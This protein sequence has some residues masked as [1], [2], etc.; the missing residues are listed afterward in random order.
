MR[1]TATVSEPSA[2]SNQWSH[3]QS[4]PV[5]PYLPAFS[6]GANQQHFDTLMSETR[7]QNSEIRMHLCRLT[8]KID[9]ALQKVKFNVTKY[10]LLI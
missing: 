10:R 2:Y 3:Q 8:D 6:G 4:F 7:T 1:P 5:M 9:Y